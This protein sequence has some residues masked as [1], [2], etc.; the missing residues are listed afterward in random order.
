VSSEKSLAIVLK[1]VDFSETSAV[2][3]LLTRSAGKISGLAK[4][5][6]R[7]KS[8][9]FGAIDTLSLSQI[10]FIPRREG[11]LDLLTEAKLVRR[12]RPCQWSLARLYAGYYVAE[13]LYD[14]TEPHQPLPELFQLAVQSLDD[15]QTSETEFAYQPVS[16][17]LLRFELRMLQLL[18]HGLGLT[19]CAGC[20]TPLLPL[21]PSDDPLAIDHLSNR[22]NGKLF[23]SWTDTSLVCQACHLGRGRLVSFSQRAAQV[24]RLFQDEDDR[25]WRRHAAWGCHPVF[26][27]L[28]DG[29]W[30]ALL[31]RRL[32]LTPAIRQL[33]KKEAQTASGRR[34]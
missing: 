10:Q 31:N 12:F 2:I 32:R 4:G 28:L 27:D 26:R 30:Q 22:R 1:V 8:A 3:S 18:G 5:A 20:D 17:I 33:F 11:T 24:L 25:G 23:F 16:A 15:L 9:F 13:L 21:T 7:P 14:L 34:N 19:H 6:R 29:Q